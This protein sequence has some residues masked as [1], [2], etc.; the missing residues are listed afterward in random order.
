MSRTTQQMFDPN[1]ERGCL[2]CEAVGFTDGTPTMKFGTGNS[3]MDAGTCGSA[4]AL[5]QPIWGSQASRASSASTKRGL[6][7]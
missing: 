3:A 2:G 4:R 5:G 7:L 1:V 6:M